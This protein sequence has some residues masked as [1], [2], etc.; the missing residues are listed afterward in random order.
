MH[1]AAAMKKIEQP[2]R[3]ELAPRNSVKIIALFGGTHPGLHGYC[4]R[5]IVLGRGRKEQVRFAPGVAKD[6]YNPRGKDLFDHITPDQ[7]T[8]AIMSQL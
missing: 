5:T 4:K 1:L 2:V 6:M 8:D 3:E 7:L